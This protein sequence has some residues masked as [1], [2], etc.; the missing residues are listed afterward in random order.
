[1]PLRESH[2]RLR[3]HIF[4]EFVPPE[5]S[6]QPVPGSHTINMSKSQRI[7]RPLTTGLS[8]RTTV[9][10]DP[11]NSRVNWNNAPVPPPVTDSLNPF[12]RLD[13]RQ[14]DKE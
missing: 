8:T 10:F 6:T 1:M 5:P 9:T 14:H 4:D 12:R 2:E 11:V 13:S 3:S 7:S